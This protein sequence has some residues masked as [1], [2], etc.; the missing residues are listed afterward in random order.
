MGGCEQLTEMW[1]RNTKHP[2]MC[3]PHR[4][5][6]AV[7]PALCYVLPSNPSHW[8]P[9]SPPTSNFNVRRPRFTI[10]SWRPEYDSWDGKDHIWGKNTSLYLFTNEGE[11]SLPVLGQ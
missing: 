3:S 4:L 6:K 8:T 10:T 2:T 9:S 11:S 1:A 5:S 7:M